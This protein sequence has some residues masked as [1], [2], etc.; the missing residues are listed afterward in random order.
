MKFIKSIAA[1]LIGFTTIALG[2]TGCTEDP[3]ETRGAISGIVTESPA[4]TEPVAGVTVSVPSLGLSVTTGSD[5]SFV[6][7]NMI[8]DTYTL[9]LTKSGYV[10][11]TRQVTVE[12]GLNT[13]VSLQMAREAQTAVITVT[14]SAL[15]FGTIQTSMAVTIRNNGN[16]TADWNLD[17]GNNV[18][19]NASQIMGS[20]QPGST[21][22]IAFTVDRSFV[23]ETRTAIVT[24]HAFGSDYPISVS[25]SPAGATSEMVIEPSELDFGTKFSE[26]TFMVRNTGNS[27]LAWQ[28]RNVA[29]GL[30]LSQEQGTV[31]AGG[32]STVVVSLN[33][34][35][36]TDEHR[37]T[38]IISD[39][40]SDHTINVSANAT[41]NIGGGDV[42]DPG[43]LVAT[44]CLTSYYQFE[45]DCVD[46]YSGFDGIEQNNPQYVV[47]LNGNALK[48]SATLKTAAHIPYPL[49]HDKQFSFS[50]WVKDLGSNGTIFYAPGTD[51]EDRF[52][53]KMINGKLH[54]ACTRYNVNY[55]ID[56][57][58]YAFVHSSLND[59]QWHHVVL[60][61]EYISVSPWRW[62]S[63]LYVDGRKMSTVNESTS[64]NES[65]MPKA[66]EIGG[67]TTR[68]TSATMTIDNFRFYDGYNLSL[69]E[70]KAIYDA[71]Q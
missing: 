1:A 33:R 50:F 3:E 58:T 40:I 68:Q 70:I 13:S 35:I 15:N 61:C 29:L 22:S 30:S 66:L 57:E 14:P 54:F 55:Q 62:S 4:G 36:I 8:P 69:E 67:S 65:D 51:N 31:A 47:G 9:Q 16:M 44:N 27:P 48:F 23:A 53:L 25:C 20:I 38:I 34:S 2:M 12:A 39:G 6:F 41:G 52:A 59:G 32:S 46:S 19:L 42:P 11:T 60:T 37:S 49:I 17:L 10:T 21:Q 56:S 43:Q 45:G 71:R 26:L 63:T 18:W 64:N 24:L 7:R 28:A 5:G